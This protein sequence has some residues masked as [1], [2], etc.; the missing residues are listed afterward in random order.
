MSEMPEEDISAEQV[1]DGLA[2]ELEERER[3]RKLTNEQL[4]DDILNRLPFSELDAL[5]EEACTRL[6]PGWEHREAIQPLSP[7]AENL[8]QRFWGG[9]HE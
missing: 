7:A 3:V 9:N 1:A 6:D 5:I 4:V 2:R 8:L